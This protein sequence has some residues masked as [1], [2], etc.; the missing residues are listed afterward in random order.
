[1]PIKLLAPLHW[2]IQNCLMIQIQAP[3]LSSPIPFDPVVTSVVPSKGLWVPAK[4]KHVCKQGCHVV[5][6]AGQKGLAKGKMLPLLH[7]LTQ[8]MGEQVAE[9]WVSATAAKFPSL[10]RK[11]H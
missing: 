7:R 8:P 6:T 10:Q 11:M 4:A 9:G 5:V 2:S 1:M 3:A